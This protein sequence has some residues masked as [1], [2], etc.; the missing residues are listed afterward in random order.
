VSDANRPSRPSSEADR[1]LLALAAVFTPERAQAL[2]SRLEPPEAAR[3]AAEAGAAATS[4]RRARLEALALE[5]PRGHGREAAAAVEELAAPE[6]ASTAAA[7]RATVGG[8]GTRCM[9]RAFLRLVREQVVGR[10]G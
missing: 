9:T 4:S 3:L 2:L 1:R 6:R 5:L 10:A 8:T 7:L